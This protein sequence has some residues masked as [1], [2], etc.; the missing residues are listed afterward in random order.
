[1][2]KTAL[3]LL[4]VILLLCCACA[5]IGGTRH[6]NIWPLVY[7][8]EDKENN[9]RTLS[10]LTPF[11][12]YHRGKDAREFS[13]RP[14]FSIKK[15]ESADSTVI[16]ILYPLIKYKKT[17]ADE[18]FRIFP[19]MKDETVEVIPNK[20]RTAHD[21]FPLYWG[22]SEDGRSYGGLF[23]IYGTVRKRFGKDDIFFL[24]WPLYSRTVEDSTVSH[25]VLWPI[26]NKTSGDAAH[27]M[28]IFPLWGHEETTGKNYKTFILFPL[29]T[30]SG[31][32]LD[33]QS[34]VTDTIIIPF[35]VNH[36]TPHSRSTS[37][38]WPFFTVSTD[39]ETNYRKVDA[40]WPLI[41]F[42]RSDTLSLIQLAPVYRKRVTTKNDTI[43]ERMYIL[44]PIYSQGRFTS[45]EKTEES[46]R[47]M[48]I[49]KYIRTTYS[50]G[51]DD[52]WVYFFPAYDR[53]KLKSGEDST[54]V[55]YPLPLYDDG[56]KRNYLPLFEIFRHETA[57]DGTD[58]LTIL[59]HLLIRETKGDVK[60]LDIPFYFRQYTQ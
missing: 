31:K 8:D 57:A 9:T 51:S 33:T 35:Y 58:R 21:H 14:V 42:A 18:K 49:D 24:L 56:F 37:Y 39:D 28:R 55:F 47:F 17:G 34:P 48:L 52:L 5:G 50:D 46:F 45:S 22:K 25:T 38:L 54:V 3:I 32:Y 36:E 13:I 40:P 60:T 20:T 23:P 30:F 19:I 7:Y 6:V 59:H 10:I 15:D 27:G 43:D 41:S 1:M 16:D 44:Y 11:V 4:A 2:K 26:F 12:Y 53:R 29:L